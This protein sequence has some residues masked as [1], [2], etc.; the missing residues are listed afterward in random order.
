MVGGRGWSEGGA[1]REQRRRE[2]GVKG[3]PHLH[4][5]CR[6]GAVRPLHPLQRAGRKNKSLIALENYWWEVIRPQA[7]DT[8]GIAVSSLT[9]GM[10]QGNNIFFQQDQ[11][12]ISEELQ[13]SGEHG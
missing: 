6:P 13:S 5:R 12:V 8:G 1:G 9:N 2:E 11:Q 7:E 3:G 4:G 10:S